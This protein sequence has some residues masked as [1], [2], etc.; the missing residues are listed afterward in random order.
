VGLI[1][2]PGA[3]ASQVARDLGIGVDLLW[4]WRKQLE[5]GS[6]KPFPGPGVPRDEEVAAL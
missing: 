4:R 3:N 2:E 1:R 6:R 5:G